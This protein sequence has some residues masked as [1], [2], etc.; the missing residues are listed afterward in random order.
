MCFFFSFNPV[1]EAISVAEVL[2]LRGDT[3]RWIG[4]TATIPSGVSINLIFTLKIASGSH[5]GI[6]VL[7]LFF[8]RWFL[9]FR[10]HIRTS[11]STF[12]HP[13]SLSLS[14][15]LSLPMST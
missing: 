7:L 5:T 13:L 2:W 3:R 12:A 8:C 11:D 6:P 1:A 4:N 10:F 14:L 15:S 9:R